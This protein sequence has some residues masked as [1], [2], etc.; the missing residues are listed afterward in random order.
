M[1]EEIQTYTQFLI[2]NYIILVY[3]RRS[4]IVSGSFD[5]L[6]RTQVFFIGLL[7]SS[8]EARDLLTALNW[9]TVFMASRSLAGLR[10]K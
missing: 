9:I 2:K 6:F 1:V 5:E 7:S 8:M 3:L 4:S 10:L